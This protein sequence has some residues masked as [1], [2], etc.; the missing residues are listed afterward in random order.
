MQKPYNTSK[1]LKKQGEIV[2]STEVKDYRTPAE[3]EVIFL[4]TVTDLIDSMVNFSILQV[5]GTSPEAQIL[6][7]AAT[8]QRFFNILLVDLLSKCDEHLLGRQISYL[9]ALSNIC[10]HPSFN[11]GN[12]VATLRTA[13]GSFVKWLNH[14]PKVDV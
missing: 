4:S 3:E 2:G 8:H 1:R 9:E 10:D 12:S 14:E 13:T 6:L 11:E 7:H 5:V